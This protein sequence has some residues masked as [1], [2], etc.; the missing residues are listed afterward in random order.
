MAEL[1]LVPSKYNFAFPADAGLTLF[2]TL[3]GATYTIDGEGAAEL[4]RYL[5]SDA[6]AEIAVL[7]L[8][9]PVL[10]RLLM[11]GYLIS[12]K[13]PDQVEIVRRRFAAAKVDAPIVLTIV[14][15]MKC[16][17]ACYYCYETRTNQSLEDS[18][19]HTIADWVSR[20]IDSSG[21]RSLHVDWFGGEPLLNMAFIE[22][23][24]AELQAVCLAKQAS[25][26]ASVISNG[27]LW[28][29]DIGAFIGKHKIRQVQISL[30]GM[31]QEHDR[32]R[33]YRKG[34]RPSADASAFE[35]AASAIDA[36]LEYTR[37]DVRLNLDPGNAQDGLK[38]VQYASDKGWFQK[39]HPFKLY[40]ARLSKYSE[41]SAFMDRVGIDAE[42]FELVAKEIEAE[43]ANVVGVSSTRSEPVLPRTGVCAALARDSVVVGADKSLYRCG[44]QVSE[45]HRRVGHLN[46]GHSSRKDADELGAKVDDARWWETYDP[47]ENPRCG[48][49]SF[50]PICW[51]GCPK[52]HLERDYVA[53]EFQCNHWRRNLGARVVNSL[54]QA[55]L[56][57]GF[58]LNEFGSNGQ[59]RRRSIS[60]EHGPL[61]YGSA[62]EPASPATDILPAPR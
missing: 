24:S 61:P 29:S 25:Y 16:N 15:T 50:L 41:R 17:L 54:G 45:P 42:E 38:L 49:C 48:K 32:R 7:E 55:A 9:E 44:L 36:L 23:M 59:F 8:P 52:N 39:K 37:V 28:P 56:D 60:E 5:T 57:D 1:S 58:K 13:D 11:G 47:T 62:S 43:I 31:Q 3:S 4:A 22:T 21:K 26:S 51:G 2:N 30:D 34:Y 33:K 6:P 35:L 12:G 53:M 20:R 40:P 19:V 14:T 10:S 46:G 27:T 18:N